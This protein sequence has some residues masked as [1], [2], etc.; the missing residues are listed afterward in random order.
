MLACDSL[1]CVYLIQDYL[2]RKK[3]V[4][5]LHY[6]NHTIDRYRQT[7]EPNYIKTIMK[8]KVAYRY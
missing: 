5:S 8:S 3:L 7:V 2:G 6:F 1:M 4:K